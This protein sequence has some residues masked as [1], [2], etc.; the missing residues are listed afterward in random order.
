M[1][2]PYDTRE[3]LRALAEVDRRF[4]PRIVFVSATAST[5]GGSERLA[6]DDRARAGRSGR[7]RLD[8]GG[9]QPRPAAAGA[10]G[11]VVRELRWALTLRH[12]PPAGAPGEVAGH[13]H[14]AARRQRGRAYAGAASSP[15][16]AVIL[17]AFGAYAGGLNVFDAVFK[18]LFPN[19]STAHLI[20]DGRLFAIGRAMLLCRD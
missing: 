4:A 6:D 3:T 19:G 7:T 20:G 13:L 12:E 18:P 1:L 9:R 2:P 14:P 11:E 16:D 10:R 15:T 5:T 8:L 17:P